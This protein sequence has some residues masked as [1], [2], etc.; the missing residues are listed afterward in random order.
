MDPVQVSARFAAYVWACEAGQA[1]GPASRFACQNWSAFLPVA[2][3]GLGRL[4]IRVAAPRVG[5]A[6]P[7]AHGRSAEKNLRHGPQP[8]L[9][10]VHS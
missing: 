2:H 10:V 8:D 4:L 7:S 1:R 3:E 5:A 6:R 9:S